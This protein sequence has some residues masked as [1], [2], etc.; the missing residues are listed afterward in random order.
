MKAVKVAVAV[1]AIVSAGSAVAQESPRNAVVN[2]QH[3]GPTRPSKTVSKVHQPVGTPHKASSF[4]PHPTKKRVFGD[5]I[6]P[7][8]VHNVP[9]APSPKKTVPK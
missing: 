3:V 2:A 6:Q 7:P 8:I 9:P 1:L 4:A 5:P